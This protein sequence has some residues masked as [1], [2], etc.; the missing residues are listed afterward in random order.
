MRR[1]ASSELIKKLDL[2]KV[3]G[4]LD[5]P[6]YR[7]TGAIERKTLQHVASRPELFRF[8]KPI[9][10]VEGGTS[11]FIEPFDIVRGFPKIQRTLVLYP[12]LVT[13]FS[14]CNKVAVEEKMNGYNTRLALVG[15][16]LVGLT[17]GGFLCPYTTEKANELV[18]LEFF[19]D[20]P[21]LVICGEMVGPDSPY[22]PKSIYD[23]ESLDFFAFDVREKI[24]GKPMPVME[25]RGL[26]EEYGINSARFFGEYDVEE[27]HNEI[28][29]IIKGFGDSLHEGV[30][31]K[32][33]QMVITPV[34]YTSSLSNCADLRYAFEFYNDYGRDFFFPRVCR[35]AFQSMEWDE[36]EESRRKRCLRLG[37]S[38]LLP[39]IETIKKKKN[40]ERIA[41]KVQIRVK[42]LKTALDFETHLRVLGVDA[43][44]E[45]PEQIGDEYLIRIRKIYHSTND[46]TE[47]ILRGEMW[48]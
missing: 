17:R 30:V 6:D 8:D 43:V 1:D 15:D 38:I 36:D 10:S 16:E 14:S 37:E 33:P 7:L 39:M 19:L 29:G 40:G 34:K 12:G 3:S 5:I 28:T 48:S 25:R 20:H 2:E 45:E 41:E 23:I 9:S 46:K 4:L 11:I 42:N 47:S 13:H 26:M 21:D 24:S 18:G 27:A 22:V 44:F 31:I 32:D 35:E